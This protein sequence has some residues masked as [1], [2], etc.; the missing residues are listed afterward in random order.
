LRASAALVFG[1]VLLA[2]ALADAQLIPNLNTRRRQRPSS[3]TEPPIYRTVRQQYYGYFPT[4]WRKFPPGWGCPC[5]NPE[6]PQPW[7]GAPSGAPAQPETERPSEATPP[8]DGTRRPAPSAIPELPP[9]STS[10]FDIKPESTPP[11]DTPPPAPAPGPEVKPPGEARLDS[12]DPFESRALPAVIAPPARRPVAL[13][14]PGSPSAE[15]AASPVTDALS[16][17]PAPT[18]PVQA[19]KRSFLGGVFDRLR[20]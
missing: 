9:S 6:A 16:A 17:E 10:P 19:P 15:P 3:L 13:L 2:P 14:D 4:C 5:P 12:T 20:R 18:Q 11:R 7:T 8:T 1:M